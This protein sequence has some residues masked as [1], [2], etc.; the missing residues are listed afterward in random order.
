MVLLDLLNGIN[1]ILLGMILQQETSNFMMGRVSSVLGT[2]PVA[3]TPLGQMVFGI[4]L[5][6][7]PVYI[8]VAIVSTIVIVLSI[9]FKILTSS[10]SKKL[11][12]AII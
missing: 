12:I 10:S 6:K 11:E 4:L 9:I 7:I 8:C 3:D 1:N 2:L 5:D